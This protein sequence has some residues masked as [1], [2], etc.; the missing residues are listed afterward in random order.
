MLMEDVLWA[1]FDR[2]FN[3]EIWFSYCGLQ[4]VLQYMDIM[5]TNT[6]ITLK[7]T[8]NYRNIE[9]AVLNQYPIPILL[10]VCVA[11]RED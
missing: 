11:K 3:A 7:L 8:F 2:L 5:L 9:M 4:N 10:K 6:I 1:L